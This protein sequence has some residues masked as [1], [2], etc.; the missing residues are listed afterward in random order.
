V[1]HAV[2]AS[3]A[4]FDEPRPPP[5]RLPVLVIDD[6][7][8]TR[9]LE[10]SILRSAGYEVD[11]ACSGEEGLQK[12]S[13][14]RYGLYIVDVEMPGMNGFEFT[15]RTRADV[16][17]RATPVIL[18]TSLASDA[19]KKRGLDAGASGYIV[20]GEF[21]QRRFLQLVDELVG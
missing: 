2:H 17:Q 16:G 5:P 11:L 8:T 7:L 9:M 15:A 3:G 6:S 20:K 12:A 21:D 4:H 14:R 10:H 13:A 18:V 19:D 1:E